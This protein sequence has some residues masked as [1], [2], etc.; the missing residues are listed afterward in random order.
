MKKMFMLVVVFVC[1]CVLP[2][3]AQQVDTTW[4]R[5]FNGPDNGD[6]RAHAMV[7]D[8]SGNVYVTGTI[9][10]GPT[11][12]YATVK[13]G[14]DGTQAWVRTYAGPAGTDVSVAIA[15]DGLGNVCVT[16]YSNIGG[17][18]DYVTIKYDPAGNQL[19]LIP[20]NRGFTEMAKDIAADAAGNVYVT[21]FAFNPGNN[22]INYFTLKYLPGGGAAWAQEFNGP[23]NGDDTASA[24]AVDNSGNVFVV[25]QCKMSQSPAPINRA[26][27]LV[28]YDPNGNPLLVRYFG[29]PMGNY[30]DYPY[31]LATDAAGNVYVTGR[32]GSGTNYITTKHASDGTGQWQ[33]TY[34]GPGNS[35]DEAKALAVD[36]D[37]NVY[38][39]GYSVGSGTNEDYA[40]IKYRSNGDTAWVRRYDGPESN[41]D[42][43][44]AIAI[45]N[46]G[47]VYVT[48][49]SYSSS[50]GWDYATVKYDS[51]GNQCWVQKYNGPAGINDVAL[52]IA[53]NNFGNVY[54]TGYSDGGGTSYDYATIKYWQDYPPVVAAVDSSK[55]FCHPDTIRFTVTAF[56]SDAFDSITLSGPGIT[57]VKGLSPLSAIAKIY[58]PSAG[59]YSYIYTVTD[60]HLTDA[61]T[62]TWTITTNTLPSAFSLTAPADNSFLTPIIPFDWENA[63]DPGDTVT[64]HLNQSTSPTFNPDSTI[65]D[66]LPVSQCTDTLEF[67]NY[68]WKV[69]ADDGCG[70]TWSTQTWQFSACAGKPGDA[71]SSGT[72]TLSDPIAIVNY[73]FNKPGCTP[74]PLCWLSGLLCRGDWDGSGTVTLADVIRGVNYIFNKPG[75]P[76]DAIPVGVCCLP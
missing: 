37:G 25:G 33:K 24:I 2:V 5:R 46:A 30:N 50:T 14:S 48:G 22:N 21:G 36:A 76:W 39:T 60:G 45:D 47:N 16:G 26:I 53:A 12:D 42:E 11:P 23:A 13:Y 20:F 75:G 8:G 49:Q 4:L 61:D 66:I 51:S 6:D 73:I 62:A 56:D 29:S 7:V 18:F 31:D 34:N 35:N 9:S 19:W 55:Y 69:R 52:G 65:I 74:L 67:G 64:Y 68:Y 38:V 40:T 57:T 43:A 1:F 27:G 41:H 32:V 15:L 58:A 28:K 59:M 63:A 17:A 71:N 70:A 44:T 72:Y 3:L 54:I 10:T